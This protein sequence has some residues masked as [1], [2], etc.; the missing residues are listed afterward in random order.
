MIRNSVHIMSKKI[1]LQ[2]DQGSTFTYS[3]RLSDIA[4]HDIDFSDYT[5][6][7]T[8]RKS[9]EANTSTPFVTSIANS[10]L[11]LSL[12]ANTAAALEACRQ[13]YDVE[14]VDTNG[15]VTRLIEGVATINPEVTKTV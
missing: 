10:T 14:I 13:V 3:A 12:D 9:Y 5:S 6:R 2:I 8:I 11:T 4:N 1:N 7:A 15:V